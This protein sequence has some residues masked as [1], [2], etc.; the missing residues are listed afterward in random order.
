M[1]ALALLKAGFKWALDGNDKN[2]IK[3]AV[4][5][6]LLLLTLGVA[7]SMGLY[8]HHLWTMPKGSFPAASMAPVPKPQGA[9]HER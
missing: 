6:G 1:K 2:H 5:L 7:G 8:I 9:N 3:R 4:L